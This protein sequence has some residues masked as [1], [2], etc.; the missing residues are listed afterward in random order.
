[1]VVPLDFDLHPS[2]EQALAIARC[3]DVVAS[4]ELHEAQAL[5][6][7]LVDR[8]RNARLKDGTVELADL[9]RA[10]RTQI[11]RSDHPD[12]CCSWRTVKSLTKERLATIDVALPGGLRLERAADRV[13]L[14]NSIT[15]HTLTVLHG[16]SGC[17]K[18]ALVRSLD[19][20]FAD[21]GW[22]WLAPEDC[23]GAERD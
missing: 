7:A 17:G 6:S 22:V 10:L 13:K 14:I 3:R 2:Q 16:D 4:G 23:E 20:A 8:A 9:W 15:A 18:S 21:W 1:M 12:F 11:S 19:N 5:W